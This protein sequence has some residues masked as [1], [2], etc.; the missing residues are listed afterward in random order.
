VR[1]LQ[2]VHGIG[3]AQFTGLHNER[4]QSRY[5]AQQ[6]QRIPQPSL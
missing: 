2:P 5:E 4:K 3:G 6:E 1:G